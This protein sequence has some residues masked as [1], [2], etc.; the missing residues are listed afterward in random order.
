MLL[1]IPNEQVF[2]FIQEHDRSI[3]DEA[4]KSK[5]V[6]CSPVTLFAVLSVI[7]QAVHN[8]ALEQT[9]NEI[10]TLFGTFKKQWGEFVKKMETVGKRIEIAHEEYEDL[11]GVRTRQLERPLAAIDALR[12][13][14]E[15][16]LI[17]DDS[18]NVSPDRQVLEVART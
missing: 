17:A 5:V 11:V 1:F 13:H 4:L 7:R 10:L 6:T 8:F 12:I 16:P 18:A 9:S 14:K 2:S 15:L 3:L